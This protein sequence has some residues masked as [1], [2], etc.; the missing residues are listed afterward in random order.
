MNKKNEIH[1]HALTVG[2]SQMRT[3]S[4]G[5]DEY[6]AIQFNSIVVSYLIADVDDQCLPVFPI[7]AIHKS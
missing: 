5:I 6:R 3:S 2:H 1:K 7:R 4:N